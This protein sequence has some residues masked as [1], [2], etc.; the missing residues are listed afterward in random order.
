MYRNA[1]PS[2]LLILSFLLAFP[3]LGWSQQL[4]NE[5][6]MFDGIERDYILYLP[7]S[8]TTD[9]PLVF[10]L[11]GYGS[12]GGEQMLYSGMNS[13][14]DEHGFAVCYPRGTNDN[15]GFPHWNA[16]LNIST[17][18]D[19]GFLTA[20]AEYLQ[21]EYILDSE[22]TFSC[23][24]SN[25]GF[26]SYHLACQAPE[27]FKAIASVTGTMSSGTFDNCSPSVP[28]PVLEIH[29]T[30]DPVV[31]YN[32]TVDVPGWGDF[33][34]TEIVIDYWANLNG[35]SEYDEVNLPDTDPNDGSTV[36]SR[37]YT[38][39][40]TGNRVWLYTVIGG[41]HDWPGAVFGTANQDFEASELIWEFFSQYA[42]PSSTQE[43]VEN[44]IQLYPNP[45]SGPVHLEGAEW[46]ESL[47]LFDLSG[48]KIGDLRVQRE[49][50][51]R[52][53]NSGIYLLKIRTRSGQL[54]QQKLIV[55]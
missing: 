13:V 48:R 17:T 52:F 18:D 42:P 30:A 54:S 1:I 33:I 36:V 40:T 7:A 45:S 37:K 46:V 8:L 49:L 4:L 29:G 6:I 20:L 44:T 19:V 22:R 41:G 2:F 35:C 51:V 39:C 27:T 25:G 12:N 3:V 31:P 21:N 23:G 38:D 43:I 50:N 26:M 11:H 5:S 28:V 16:G 34:G 47:E 53:L 24:M 14:A 32:G 10:N 15:Q 55:H 9:A